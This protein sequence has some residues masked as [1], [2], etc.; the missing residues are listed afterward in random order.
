MFWIGT[1]ILAL[2]WG[3]SYLAI[4]IAVKQT[5]PF[6]AAMMRVAVCAVLVFVLW[7]FRQKRKNSLKQIRAA[8]FVGAMNLGVAWL[9]LFWAEKTI[10][11]SLAAL[12]CCAVPI[13]VRLL[14]PL[15]TPGDHHPASEWLG[16][17]VGF[18]GVFLLLWPS[19][20]SPDPSQIWAALAV[21]AMAACYAFGV[22]G[23]RRLSNTMTYSDLLFYQTMGGLSVLAVAT[24]LTEGFSP[25]LTWTD[26]VWFAILYLGIFSTFIAWLIFFWMI[27]NQGSVKAAIVPY[28][29][30]FVSLLLDRLILHTL[31]DMLS[32]MGGGIIL[33]GVFLTQKADVIQEF[34]VTPKTANQASL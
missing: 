28:F 8:I 29:V 14:S 34:F 13:F 6:G 5:P 18:S 20:Q 2:F 7:L 12:I 25:I 1:T 21:L 16:I 3:G 27:K 24:G 26:E 9:F 15:V 11:P 17:G 32:L 31:P 4:G 33:A 19:W 23:A 30:P 10:L 22:V